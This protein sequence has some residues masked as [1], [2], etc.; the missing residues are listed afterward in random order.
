MLDSDGFFS[1]IMWLHLKSEPRQMSLDNSLSQGSGAADPFGGIALRLA[2]HGWCVT[3][4]FL[5]PL[6]T[7]QLRHDAKRLWRRGTFRHAGVGRG[8][9]LQIRPEV[10]TDHVHWLEREQCTG[11]QRLYLDSLEGLRLA[12]NRTLLLGLFDFEGHLAVYPTGSYYRK[13]L[14]QFRGVGMRTV[15]CVL[16]LNRDWEEKD[17]G[18]LRIYTDPNDQTSCEEVLPLGGT[19]VTFLSARF[20]HEVLP[21]RRERISITG[22]FKRRGD[23][24]V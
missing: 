17:G 19:L 1:S 24:P 9:D 16:Y 3:R 10:R 23:R 22:W 4:D 20:L 13:H 12:L 5:P 2:D 8:E 14:D 6:L 7:A 11:A 18:Q 15:T 21:A